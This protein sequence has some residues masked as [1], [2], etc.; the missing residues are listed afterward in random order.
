MQT[1]TT[2]NGRATLLNRSRIVNACLRLLALFVRALSTRWTRACPHI[3]NRNN[4]AFKIPGNS[5]KPSAERNSNRNTAPVLPSP[6]NRRDCYKPVARTSSHS[7]L[8]T[9]HCLFNRQQFAAPRN[10]SCSH[11]SRVANHE[12][13]IA[14]S[15]LDTNGRF[16]RNNNSRNSFKTND[17]VNSYSI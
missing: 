16:R 11:E 5:M 17:R 7:P 2:A 4:T 6:K 14:A 12:S 1:A 8:A 10:T 3:S 15:L 13:R 9:S